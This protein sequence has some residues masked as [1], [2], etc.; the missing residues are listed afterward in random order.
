MKECF[1]IEDARAI[2][3]AD[4]PC[5]TPL[6]ALPIRVVNHFEERRIKEMKLFLRTLFAVLFMFLPMAAQSEPLYAGQTDKGVVRDHNEDSYILIPEHEVF[7]VADGMGGH[8]AGEV[9]SMM[10][11]NTVKY[12]V[13]LP[14][15]SSLG[16]IWSRL[17]TGVVVSSYHMANQMILKDSMSVSAHRGMGNTM[18]SLVVRGEYADIINVGDSRAY[19]LRGGKIEQISH[20]QSLV[21]KYIDDGVLKTPEEIEAFPYKNIIMQAMGTQE[22]IVPDIFEE[23][24]EAGDI[25]LLCSDGLTN[26]VSDEEIA[27]IILARGEDLSGAAS[28]LIARANEA[29]GKDNITAVIVRF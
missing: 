21:Q 11:V 19:R 26:E 20:D 22:S 6:S 8:A 13:N 1:E 12:V 23:K 15:M 16:K 2:G 27:K 24:L 7:V 9:A 17:R 3:C 28:E 5:V 18:V 14:G 25:Y 29:G 10:A 4:T